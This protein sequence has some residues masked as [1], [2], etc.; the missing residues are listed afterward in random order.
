MLKQTTFMGWLARCSLGYLFHADKPHHKS[1]FSEPS[2][3]SES[4][5]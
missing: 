3:G 5:F 2:R 4:G 1:Y